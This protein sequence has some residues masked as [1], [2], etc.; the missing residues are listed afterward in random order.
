MSS[1]TP[2]SP[3][4]NASLRQKLVPYLTKASHLPTPFLSAFL[5]VHLSAP[6]VAN[7]GGPSLSSQVML[8]GREYYQGEMNEIFLLFAPLALHISASMLKRFVSPSSPRPPTS[9]LT[10][11]GYAATLSIPIHVLIHRVYPSDPSEPISS[12]GP[13]QLDFSFVQHAL[14]GWPVRSVI[15]YGGLIVGT[16]LHTLEGGA[17]LWDLYFAKEGTARRGQ[18]DRARRRKMLDAVGVLSFLAGLYSLWQEP[19][20]MPLPSILRRFDTILSHS[21][22]YRL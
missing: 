15:M 16:L 1:S 2:S 18:K 14:Q 20:A 9:L 11:A 21:L 17:L 10:I 19:I 5:L 12:L 8:L 7:I 4:T 6:L 22:V 13:A 3:S